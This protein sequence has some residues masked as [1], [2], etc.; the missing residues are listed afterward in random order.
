MDVCREVA[1]VKAS[2]STS[3]IQP[4]R[5]REVLTSRRQWAINAG[6][7]ADFAEQIFRT[8]LAETHRIEVAHDHP[9]TPPT[10][11][12]D[13]LLTALDTVAVR[14]DHI[15]VTVAD[16][17]AARAFATTLGFSV[18]P[19]ADAGGV[20]VVF[21]GPG[22]DAAVKD[23][24]ARHGSGVQHVAIEVLNASF[25]K[26][27]LAQAGIPMLTDVV[28]DSAGHEQLFTVVDP[29]TGVQF[30]FISRT[31][32]RVPISGH[33]VRALFRALGK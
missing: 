17:D 16:L 14:I 27:A 9:S 1:E 26:D 3:V 24:L 30:G 6:V 12:A 25:V 29:S 5:V 4:S 11:I 7:D 33:N 10:K 22:N 15:V 18:K 19:T 32:H 23:H 31:G 28:V 20:T 21:V 2:S 13:T 8:V